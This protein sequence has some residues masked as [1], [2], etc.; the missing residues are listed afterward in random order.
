MYTIA[1]KPNRLRTNSVTKNNIAPAILGNTL[2]KLVF[3]GISIFFFYNIIH[4]VEITV[5]KLNILKAARKEVES[6]RVTNLELATQLQ[7]MQSPEYIEVEARDRLNFSGANDVIFV[8]PEALLESASE[9]LTMIL[10]E[11]EL[12]KKSNLEAWTDLLIEGS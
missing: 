10:D 7:S 3:I 1:Y 5:Q 2:V 12:V 9:R 8:I 6:L 4:S 11:K